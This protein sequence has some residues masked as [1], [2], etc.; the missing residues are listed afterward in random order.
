MVRIERIFCMHYQKMQAGLFS[1][2]LAI[3]PN[4]WEQDFEAP[5]IGDVVAIDLGDGVFVK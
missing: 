3:H 1:C 2:D 5:R 4:G